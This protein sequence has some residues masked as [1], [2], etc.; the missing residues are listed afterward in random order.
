MHSDV[1]IVGGGPA[2]LSAAIAARAKGFRVSVVDARKPP[3]D[4]PCG[5]GLLPEAVAALRSLGVELDAAPCFRFSGIRFS[6]SHSSVSAQFGGATAYGMR[7][8][9]LHRLLLERAE[10]CGVSLHWGAPLENIR[11]CQAE[12]AG[13]TILFQWLVAAD[14]LNSPIRRQAGLDSRW[15]GDGRFAFRRHFAVQPWSDVVEVNWGEACQVIVTPTTRNE[16]CVALFSSDHRLRLENAVVQFPELARRLAGARATSPERG[17]QTVLARAAT[18]VRGNL[19]LIGD[20]SCSIDGVAGQGL[21]L[22]FQAA[23][24]LASALEREDLGLYEKAHRRFTEV[25]MNM[26]RL[27]LL[28][29]GQPW[30]RRKALR[31]FAST[32]SLFSRMM[33]IHAGAS[34][35]SGFSLQDLFGLGWRV[36]RA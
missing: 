30:I 28:M 19:V 22:S 9:T 16:I 20:A 1:L 32:P 27:L 3:I 33:A 14:G 36:L 8:T 24:H 17:A 18:V 23:L 13:R 12:I 35:K 34:E 29:A 25:P 15:R 6:D 4:K 2:G 21:N 5:E 7:R 11:G 26:T 31:M 10:E